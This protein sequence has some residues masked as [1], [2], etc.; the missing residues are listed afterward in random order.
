[1]YMRLA[2]SVAAHLEPEILLVDEVLAVG[3][4]IFQKKC[5]T[6]MQCVGQEGRTVVFVSHNMTAIQ[7]LCNR[8]VWIDRGSVI[9]NGMP[10]HV[11]GDYLRTSASSTTE[12]FWENIATAPGNEIVRIRRAT[13]RLQHQQAL[14]G[15]NVRT[16]FIMEFEYW[17]LKPGTFLNLS[18]HVLN[19]EGV[20][21]FNTG[22][23]YEQ[24]WHGKPFPGGLF[25]SICYVPGDLLN[26][27][28][29]RVQLL[30][31]QN[32]GVIIYRHEDILTF[33]VQE[34]IESRQGYLGEWPGVVRPRLEWQTELLD[35]GKVYEG[36]R[37]GDSF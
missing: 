2:F 19:E 12:Q 15:I 3:D 32:Q 36:S 35:A 24:V 4:A 33:D 31:V 9:Q 10:A 14:D 37:H 7:R 26:D 29:H 27:G 22:P 11:V 34:A 5:L 1:M 18:L 6:K 23:A 17:N 21:V 16:P 20:C 25:R 28:L 13:V 30:V 8:V